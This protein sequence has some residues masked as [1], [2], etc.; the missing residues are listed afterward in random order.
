[1]AKRLALVVEYNGTR[2]CGFQLQSN[3]CTVQG[4]LETAL[5]K[6]TG[7]EIRIAGA[8][9]TDTG[10]HALG[11]VITF[12][13]ECKYPL[14][15]W[16][17]A[18]N[19]CLPEDIAIRSAHEVDLYFDAR[20]CA[21]N[22]EYRYNILNI[23]NRSPLRD[24]MAYL[25]RQKLNVAAMNRCCQALLGE[26]DF[27]SFVSLPE[28]DKRSTIRQ[29]EKAEVRRRGEFVVFTMIANAFLPHQLR[30]TVGC[31]IMVGSGKL[32][33][34]EFGQMAFSGRPGIMGPAAPGRGLCLVRVNYPPK[35]GPIGEG[36]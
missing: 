28:G 25:V 34:E 35:W 24:K 12:L 3:K 5:Y 19:Y 16:V 18:L 22:R 9:R 13:T 23:E 1:V 21:I 11:Q 8:S 36:L 17:N 2:Y 33:E 6:F 32:T 4:E 14:Q 20:R 10:V 30:N 29:V 26:H 31:L 15:A 27:I 7:E